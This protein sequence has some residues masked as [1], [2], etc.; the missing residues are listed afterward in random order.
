MS[1]LYWAT[2]TP[3]MRQIMRAVGLSDL[4]PRFYLAG[5]TALALQLG[6][7]RSV[8][9][10]FFSETDEVPPA[11]HRQVMNVLEEYEPNIV[12]QAWGNLLLLV[13]DLRVGFFGYGY[14]LVAPLLQV[15]GLS[16]CS[17]DDIGLMKLDALA[18]RANRG[19]LVL[20]VDAANVPAVA[21][22]RAAGFQVWDRRRAFF[23]LFSHT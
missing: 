17:L 7:R 16:L 8:D 3:L 18:G 4:G 21:M 10:D 23:R 6:H 19:R 2:V 5:G 12:E 15:E 22:Y 14:P 13:Q 9:L 1:E 20:A 11:T